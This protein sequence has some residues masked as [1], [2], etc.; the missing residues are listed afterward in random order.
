MNVAR[1]LFQG[2]DRVVDWVD[3]AVGTVLN[4]LPLGEF[5]EA[6]LERREGVPGASLKLVAKIGGLLAF[7][8]Y[9]VPLGFKLRDWRH[10]RYA[11]RIFTADPK[12]P[13]LANTKPHEMAI[14]AARCVSDDRNDALCQEIFSRLTVDS[15]S[16]RTIHELAR[17]C[18]DHDEDIK[19]IH[20]L[21]GAVSHRLSKVYE[22]IIKMNAV[23]DYISADLWKGR[24]VYQRVEQVGP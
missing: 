5:E 10:K 18:N 13:L 14:R 20:K 4:V 9:L 11:D 8:C 16:M 24:R 12:R 3:S 15:L 19:E 17:E 21:C 7:G 6:I 23:F 2:G 1:A 22:D